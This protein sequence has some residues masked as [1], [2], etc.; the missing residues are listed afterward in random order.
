[1]VLSARFSL[2]INRRP[3]G[4]EKGCQK[5]GHDIDQ[6]GRTKMAEKI[7]AMTTVILKK[8]TKIIVLMINRR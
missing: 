7:D 2:I 3:Q 5:V 4:V 8:K 6:K 1:M